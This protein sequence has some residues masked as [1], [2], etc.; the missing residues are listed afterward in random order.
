MARDPAP[1]L[2]DVSECTAIGVW[3]SLRACLEVA[4][5]RG[6]VRVAIQG[7]GSV[8]A[9]LARILAREGMELL[10]A[11]VSEERAAAVARE[12]RARV[13]SPEDILRAD[14]DVLAPC[15]LGGVLDAESISRLACRIVCGSANNVLATPED[16]E[17]LAARGIFYAPDY[18]AN[19][20]G[21]IRGVEFFFLGRPDSSD[22]LARVYDRTLEVFRLAR[23]RGI[24]PSRAADE[25]AESRLNR[26]KT[27]RDLTWHSEL[28]A[29][30]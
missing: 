5:I 13:L 9:W 14:A 22:S 1:G 12:T 8:G 21:L 19:A 24:S 15:A 6:K 26:R 23:E 29:A 3:H 28:H 20:G 4:G 17:A 16:G 7:V 2:G 10:V 11:D 18:L 25:L 27:F 30:G